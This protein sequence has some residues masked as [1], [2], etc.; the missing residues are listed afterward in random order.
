M[1][2]QAFS[3]LQELQKNQLAVNLASLIVHDGKQELN[4][5]NLNKVLKASGVKVPEYW[6]ELVCRA[7]SGKNIGDFL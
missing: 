2:C 3:D 5:E 6:P 1:S 7:L 4:N